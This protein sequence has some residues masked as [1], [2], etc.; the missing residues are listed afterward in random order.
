MLKSGIT[1]SGFFIVVALL[2]AFYDPCLAYYEVARLSSDT[3]DAIALERSLF[4]RGRGALPALRGGLKSESRI[5]RLRCARILALM[6][7]K[8][9][10]D[11]LLR[12]LQDESGVEVAQQYLLSIWDLR[13]A[14]PPKARTQVMRASFRE[15]TEREQEQLD[16]IMAKHPAWVGGYVLRARWHLQSNELYLA[17]RNAITALL[18]EEDNFEAAVLLGRCHLLLD[19]YE[20]AVFCLERAIRINPGLRHLVE[21]EL[22]E[23]RREAATDRQRRREK[24]ATERPVA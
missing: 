1:I 21:D 8:S 16:Q 18:L 6:G 20:H 2:W 19:Y 17:R 10:Q 13:R 4:S 12:E 9:G 23:A 5:V 22:E 3:H 24:R 14:P 15:P 7:E 11:T